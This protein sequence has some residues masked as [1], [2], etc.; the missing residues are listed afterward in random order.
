MEECIE[1][2]YVVLNVETNWLSSLNCDLLS[3][4]IYKPDNEKIYERQGV[5][6]YTQ[7]EYKNNMMCKD[8]EIIEFNGLLKNLVKFKCKKC[9]KKWDSTLK[10]D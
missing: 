2:K 6:I 10:M 3:I 4:S 8:I 9:D 1:K 5:K 7:V